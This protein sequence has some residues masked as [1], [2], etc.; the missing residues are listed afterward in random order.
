VTL[1]T[2]AGGCGAVGAGG[3]VDAFAPDLL[4]DA[5][6]DEPA[7]GLETWTFDGD[8]PPG[9]AETDVEP[10]PP[11]G[12]AFTETGA[13]TCGL[14]LAGAGGTCAAAGAASA[15]ISNTIKIKDVLE[16]TIISRLM[17]DLLGRGP[18]WHARG[19]PIPITPQLRCAGRQHKVRYTPGVDASLRRDVHYAAGAR[20]TES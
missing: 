17:R 1:D 12:F 10:P 16:R 3:D 20:A 7:D 2:A 4:A 8:E 9:L 11:G 14:V 5:C 18:R 19:T 15:L 13:L 6:V